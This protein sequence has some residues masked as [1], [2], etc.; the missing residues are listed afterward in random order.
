[1]LDRLQVVCEELSELGIWGRPCPQLLDRLSAGVNAYIPHRVGAGS[2]QPGGD[3]SLVLQGG[4]DPGDGVRYGAS[5]VART[6]SRDRPNACSVPAHA[7]DS[8]AVQS[9]V[10]PD[11]M[12]SIG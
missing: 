12:H 7:P 8:W 5:I 10:L 9:S 11:I 1:M 4:V 6:R 3:Q 2:D